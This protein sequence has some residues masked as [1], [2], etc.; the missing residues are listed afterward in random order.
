MRSRCSTDKVMALVADSVIDVVIPAAGVGKRMGADCPKQY[1]IV[2]DFP[3]LTHTINRLCQLPY[4]RNVVLAISDSDSYFARLSQQPPYTG[5]NVHWV[6]GGKERANSVLAGLNH[7]PDSP[8]GWVLV[9]DAARPNID[10]D[11]V[12]QLVY[13]CLSQD[14]GGILASP[15]KDTI[16]LGQQTV[17]RTVPREQLWH[18]L[19]P[20]FFKLQPLRHALSQGIELQKPITD[21][22]SAMELL[23]HQVLLVEGRSDNIKVTR[24]EDLALM[25]FYLQ[26]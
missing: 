12:N 10:G 13:Q 16:K 4:V 22:A 1:L 26:Q 18:A 23:D 15:V 14:C 3:I 6:I 19:T 20:Q 9:H 8:D 21:E 5:E 17:K 7:L 25:G 2:N 11:D 24:P